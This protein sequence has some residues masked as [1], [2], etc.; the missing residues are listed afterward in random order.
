MPRR[1][2]P[3]GTI[4]PTEMAPKPLCFVLM[5]FGRKPDATGCIIDFDAVHHEILAPAIAAAGL[6]PLRAYEELQGGIVHKPMFERLILCELAVADLT[7]AN[8]NVFYELGVRHALRPYTTVLVCA[9]GSRVPFDVSLDRYLPYRLDADGR[10][11]DVHPTR[12]LLAQRLEAAKDAR[13]DSPVYQLMADLPPPDVAHVKTDVF[14][15]RVRYSTGVKRR[16]D[17]ARHADIAAVQAVQAELGDLAAAES[18]VVVDVLLSYRSFGTAEGWQAMVDLVG[19]MSEPVAATVLVQEQLGFALNRLGRRRDAERVLSELIRVRGP[20]S[21]TY[22]ILGRV[23][24][25]QWNEARKA[26]DVYAAAGH[27]EKAVNAYLAGFEADWRDAYPGVNA[28]TLMALAD[29]PDAR[30]ERLVPVVRYA[31]ERRLARGVGDYWDHATLLELAVLARS[32]DDA[33]EAL[34]RAV[35][36]IREP[37]EPATTAD[38]LALIDEHRRIRGDADAWAAGIEATLRRHAGRPADPTPT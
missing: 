21:E 22:G 20:S 12:D 16:L 6:E 30:L 28:V 33:S 14:R 19:R 13:T 8:A 32:P 27:L 18:A 26:G 29:P 9:E 2:P 25:D 10:P 5:P 4:W 7:T 3:I 38:N 11:T 34:G 17:D 1:A 35:A 24:K 31:V 15:D 37:W 23:H 36:A